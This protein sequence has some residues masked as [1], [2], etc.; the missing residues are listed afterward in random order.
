[1]IDVPVV[2]IRNITK[3]IGEII[4]GIDEMKFEKGFI[5]TDIKEDVQQFVKNTSLENFEVVDEKDLRQKLLG[6]K[7]ERDDELT[8]Y[9]DNYFKVKGIG[10]VV[11]G[12]VKAG[13][14]SL[15]DK[16]LIEP[17]GREVTVKGIQSQD[18]DKTETEP[19][20]RVGLN[21]KGIEPDEIKRGYVVCRKI[22]KSDTIKIKFQKSR[23]SKQE[24][25]IG[26]PVHLSVGLQVA[27]CEIKSLGEELVLESNQKI[28]Y[29]LNQHCLIASQNNTL[30]RIIGS[31]NVV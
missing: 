20:M 14:L 31:G 4:I 3:E 26:M 29:R 11:L 16:L 30:P 15:H 9:I 1:M 10:T 24:L 12:I 23:F 28:A 19:G 8:V 13:K 7:I 22:E 25:S 5:I 27:T 2:V 6:I 18:K 21:L 17:L